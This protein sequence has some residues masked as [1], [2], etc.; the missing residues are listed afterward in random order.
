MP[1]VMPHGFYPDDA[2]GFTPIDKWLCKREAKKYR[3]GPIYTPVSLQGTIFQPAVGGGPNWG[4][5]AYDPD[6]NIMV[7]PSNRVPT[8]V[9]LVPREEANLD[10][11]Q[12]IE[13]GGKMAFENPGSPYVIEVQPLLSPLGAPCSEPP[14]AALTA[15]DLVD[16]EIVWEAPLGSI[17][18]MAPIPIDWHLGTP[19]AGGPL[20][21]ATGLVFI[22]YSLDDMFRAFDLETGEIL[23][24]TELPAAGTSIPVTYEVDGEQYVVIPAGGHSM[25]GST[26]G[27]AVMAY[28]LK[29]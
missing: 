19:G 28:K 17:K 18:N 22:G 6:T 11:N 15:V 20:L 4:G 29:R 2:W 23:W 12:K 10:K 5:A 9:R 8:V 16:K 21:T 24:E 3:Y 25:Y 13:M 27:D 26:M 1:S 7:V 14:W